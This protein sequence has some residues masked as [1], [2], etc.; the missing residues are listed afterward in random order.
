MTPISLASIGR[1]RFLHGAG[2]AAGSLACGGAPLARAAQAELIARQPGAELKLSGQ[3]G[4]IPGRDLREKVLRMEEWGMQ[5]I[6]LWGGGLPGRIQE[7]KDALRGT[8]LRVS[9]ICAGFDGVP[10]SHDPAVRE[11][12]IQ[13]INA[14]SAAAG[15]LGSTGLIIVPAF[16]GQTELG[17]VEGRKLLIEV[18]ANIGEHAH[19]AGTRILLEPLNR[20]EAWFLRLLADAAAICRDAN[21]PGV[22]V[23]GDF[24]HMNIEETSDLG[25]FLSAGA[26]LHHV[27]L[28]SAKRNLPGQDERSFVGGFRGLKAIG[29]HDYCSFECGVVGDRAVEIPK[30]LEFLRRQWAEA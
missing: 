13:S 4:V 18:L 30:S 19:R 15:E 10:I 21:H 14:I 23:M 6:E 11:Q 25:A 2:I 12:A 16:N 20:G 28:A 26:H 29:Y 27:H 22:A 9:A 3:D 24:Y 5:G 7:I 17:F 1:R 8:A